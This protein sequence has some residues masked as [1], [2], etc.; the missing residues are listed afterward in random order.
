MNKNASL[1]LS[2]KEI[3]I[4]ETLKKAYNISNTSELLR[5]LLKKEYHN[6][7]AYEGINNLSEKQIINLGL[8]TNCN[9][10]KRRK[11]NAMH[12]SIM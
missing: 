6:L 4:L 10:N 5:V 12:K 8:Y 7:M 2:D 11:E 9:T 1:R 3:E